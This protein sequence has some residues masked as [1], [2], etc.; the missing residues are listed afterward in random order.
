M[1]QKKQSMKKQ[2]IR[3]K[4]QKNKRIRPKKSKKNQINQLNPQD[5]ISEYI[6]PK[7]Q[8]I[9]SREK[10]FRRNKHLI[11]SLTMRCLIPKDKVFAFKAVDRLNYM[12]EKY[13]QKQMEKQE[14]M[15]RK[16]KRDSILNEV[17]Q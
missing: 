10:K 16:A 4:N 1:K 7:K 9:T 6:L 2:R 11:K 17:S 3:Q 5:H 15:E 12:N 13:A 14:E 8:K